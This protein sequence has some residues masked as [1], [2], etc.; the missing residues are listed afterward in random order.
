MNR[1]LRMMTPKTIAGQIA[2]LFCAALLVLMALLTGME[3]ARHETLEESVLSERTVSR[4]TSLAPLVGSIPEG[5]LNA[6]IELTSTCHAGYTVTAE[7]Y[8]SERPDERMAALR[9]GLAL[10]AGWAPDRLRVASAMLNRE[11]FAYSRC[12]ASEIDLPLEG[13]VVSAQL[14][15]GRWLN[16]EVHPHE[17]HYRELLDWLLRAG[18]LF[19]VTGALT[20]LLL[21]RLSRPLNQLTGAA[22]RFGRG[23]KAEPVE[24]DG[25]GDVRQA[26]EAFNAMQADVSGAVQRRTLAL[27]AISHDLRTPLTA[28]RLRAEMV[29]EDTVREGLITGIGRIDRV[30]A[31]AL[32]FLRGEADDTPARRF[33]L[34]ALVESESEDFMAAGEAVTVDAEPGLRLF[35]QADL[36]ARAVRNLIDNA[37]KY[38]RCAHVE[39]RAEAREA[40]LTIHDDGPGIEADEQR[41]LVEPFQRASS[42][43]DG[44]AGGLGLGLAVVDAAVRAHHGTLTFGTAVSGGMQVVIRLPVSS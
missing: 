31:S 29:A 10:T 41:R 40:V 42:A 34:S 19:L 43:R 24:P 25:P 9:S 32:D 2:T 26:I 8:P 21:R 11:D 20:L 44:A 39:L 13:V 3:L 35:G 17:W 36:M 22:R 28:L 27:A 23:L 15:D 12:S 6:L 7:P 33:D 4:L 14:D 1:V 38:G 37:V 30:V 5:R 18:G 16:L